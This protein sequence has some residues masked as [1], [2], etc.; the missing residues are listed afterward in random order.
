MLGMSVISELGTEVGGSLK[1][2]RFVVRAGAIVGSADGNSISVGDF[3]S[4]SGTNSRVGIIVGSGRIGVLVFG[5]CIIGT[6]SWFTGAL[7]ALSNNVGTLLGK[8]NDG[9]LETLDKG[10]GVTVRSGLA[11][12]VTGTGVEEGIGIENV[13]DMEKDIEVES[14][15]L[16]PRRRLHAAIFCDQKFEDRQLRNTAWAHVTPTSRSM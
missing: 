15:E 4:S 10:D 9:T 2:G 13:I 7:D 3:V 12:V 14:M 5:I 1:L 11:V 6:G 8:A 16:L